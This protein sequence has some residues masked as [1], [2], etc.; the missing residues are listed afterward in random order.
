MRVVQVS[1]HY[2]PNL[3]SGG[4][5]VPQR[6]ARGL[7]DRGHEVSVYAGHLDDDRAPLS[8]WAEDDGHG[9]R[10]RWVVTTPWTAWSDP[11]NSMNP[12]VTADFER[13]LAEVRPDVVHLHSLQT[14]GAGLVGAA[15]RSGAKVVVTS[16]DFWWSCARQFLVAPDMK[17]CSLVVDCG[18][19]PCAMNHDWLERRNALLAAQLALADVVLAPSASAARVLAANGVD[20]DRLVVDENGVPGADVAGAAHAQ[21]DRPEGG[22]VRF[23][24][25]GGSDPMKGI[26]VLLAALAALPAQGWTLDVYGVEPADLD[27]R[28]PLPGAVRFPPAYDR[29]TVAGV[30]AEHDVLVLPSVMRESHSIVTR[31]ALA[32]GMAVVCTDTLGPEEVVDDG[33]NG[34]VVPAADPESLGAAL[35]RLAADPALVARLRRGGVAVPIRD[36]TDQLDGLEDLYTGL[37]APPEKEDLMESLDVAAAQD[38]LL[39]R[40]L[41][42][43]GIRGAAL[44]YRG[45]L[46]AEALRLRGVHVDVRH[47]RD[48]EVPVLAAAAD[49]L[50]LYR[51]PATSQI[52]DVVADVRARPRPVP[53]LFDIDDLIF[54]PA[55]EGQVHGLDVLSPEEHQLWWRGVARY[56]TTMELADAY[57]GSTERLCEHATATTGLPA[58]RFANGVGIDLAQQ[59]DR[60]R[61]RPRTPG[62]LRIGYFSGTNTHDA[63]WAVVEPAVARVLAARP[64][65]ELWIGGYLTTG[66]ALTPFEGRI[67]RLPMLPWYE[68]PARLRD[69]D[70]NLAPLVLDSTFNEAKSAIKWLEAALVETPTVASPTQPF[71]EAV[72]DG[73]TGLLASS[74]QEWEQ[75]VGSLLDDALLRRRVG[76]EARREALLRWG[77]HSQAQ[78]YLDLLRAA[79]A[80][81]REHG[82][83]RPT[84]WEPVADHEP[85][86]AAEGWIDAHPGIPTDRRAA[87][88]ARAAG[89][90]GGRQAVA[91]ARVLRAGGPGAVARKVVSR[92]RGA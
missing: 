47:Y 35:A 90:P 71:R 39:G 57:V 91:A 1:A 54:D 31:E 81:R 55:L 7:A 30:M 76:A 60:A 78:V 59:S 67:R 89:L 8:T 10:V 40:V 24:F 63:D 28:R 20:A 72:A 2:P 61:R 5:L 16:H 87:L 88:V 84:G 82:P 22:P 65:V 19:C 38:A 42:V 44:R 80:H 48:P 3:V 43:V 49:A 92:V 18:T 41:L 58:F 4:T 12:Q 64:E 25:A 50:V 36:F 9:V 62:P 27:L 33:V 83:R 26:D 14:L 69:V 70:V 11:R 34:L 51:V 23:M 74:E 29:S 45:F 52:V 75:A 13:W 68:L 79:A 85:F 21:V 53:V 46:P 56:R 32:A 77:P 66:P 15:H 73:R 37:L 6:I 86:D 17:P